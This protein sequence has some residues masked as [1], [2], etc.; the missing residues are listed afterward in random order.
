[1]IGH[2]LFW[3]FLFLWTGYD[4]YILIKNGNNDSELKEKKSKYIVIIL[5]ISSFLGIMLS[6]EAKD[7]W[8]E[9]FSLIRYIGIVFMFFAFLLRKHAKKELGKYFSYDLKI[10]R[11]QIIIKSGLYKYI[12]H[13]GYLGEIMGF[14]GIA[15]SFNNIYSSLPLVILPFIA[16]NYRIVIEEKFLIKKY[17]NDYK[18]YIEETKKLFPFIY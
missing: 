16:F 11:D 3:I 2:I 15:I 5:I 14:I 7:T 12:R 8:R 17:G 6:Q 1:M 18:N 4:V 10:K 13:P 9:P